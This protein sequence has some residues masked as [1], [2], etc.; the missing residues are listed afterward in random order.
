MIRSVLA[1]LAVV[2]AAGMAPAAV[3]TKTVDYEFDGVKL[4]GFLAY[5]DS[6]KGKRPG[7]LVI[8]EW[9]GLDDYAKNRAKQLA[10]LG[11]VALAADM[12][13]DGQTTEHPDDARKMAT[14]VRQNIAIWRGRAAAA[15]QQL[16]S[17]PNVDPDKLAAIGY[18]FGGSTCI[19]LAATGAN[20][21]AI[22]TFH[23]ALP[24]LTEAEAKAIKGRL[25]ILHGA[26]DFFIKPE[27]ITSFRATLDAAKTPYEFV[28]YKDT[29]HSFT[30][31]HA[32]KHKIKGMAYNKTADEDSWKRMRQLFQETLGH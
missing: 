21:K 18:C 23:A 11:Y 8:H 9:W 15:L 20:L 31:P 7:V 28:A 17:Q 22:V 32:D 3:V 16:Q 24:K 5:D 29:V 10:E 4:K 12:Y 14:T 30:V 2:S 26:D 1:M 27:D 19:Q 6:L 13:G 25:L